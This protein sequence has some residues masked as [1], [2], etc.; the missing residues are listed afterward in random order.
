MA[1]DDLL[2]AM[3]QTIRR[4]EKGESS[5]A[6]TQAAIEANA[7]ALEGVSADLHAELREVDADLEYIQHA[8]PLDE[9]RSAALV[10]LGEL[11]WH[12]VAAGAPGVRAVPEGGAVARVTYDPRVDAAY[13]YLAEEIGAGEVDRTVPCVSI[14]GEGEVN[15]DFD[16]AGRLVGIEVLSASSILPWRLIDN[17]AS[18]DS[19]L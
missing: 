2:R 18:P 5:L 8:M 12:L 16:R 4:Y 14:G 17:P 1:N 13:V 9:Q 19:G 7:S 15:L 6:D 10:R 11:S 3:A